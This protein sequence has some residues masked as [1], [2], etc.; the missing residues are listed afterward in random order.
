[1][2]PAEIYR[3]RLLGVQDARWLDRIRGECLAAALATV[4]PGTPTGTYTRSPR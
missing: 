1:V 2:T 3:A 4:R